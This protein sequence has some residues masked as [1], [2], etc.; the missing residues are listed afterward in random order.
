MLVAKG[1][2]YEGILDATTGD[3]DTFQLDA[4]TGKIPALS[5]DFDARAAKL[6]SVDPSGL[7]EL[8]DVSYAAGS[9]GE[10]KAD[11][12]AQ[13]AVADLEAQLKEHVVLRTPANGKAR[14][15]V[16]APDVDTELAR[17]RS[18]AP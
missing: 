14:A 2:A 1:G 12:D 13:A 10:K 5:K 4:A 15:P 17:V 11:R 8:L 7:T 6:D 18:A 16:E 9:A 3:L